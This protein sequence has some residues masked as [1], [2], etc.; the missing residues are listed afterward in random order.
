MLSFLI[1]LTAQN[2]L[3]RTYRGDKGQLI[4]EITIPTI[5]VDQRKPGPV[6]VPTRSAVM[7]AEVPAFDWS[8]G[9]TATSAAMLAG[10]FDRHGYNN[11]YTGPTNGGIVPLDNSA[12]GTGEC[13]L[14]ATHTGYDNLL[15]AGHVNR[16]WTS[17]GNSGDDPFGTGNPTGTYANCTADYIGTS[18][19]WWSNADGYSTVY[20]NDDGSALSNFVAPESYTVR[21]R[22]CTRGL[23][24]FFESRGYTVTANYNQKV[25]NYDGNTLGCTFADYKQ[26]INAG[27]P[28][29]IHLLGRTL[30]HTILG[31]GYDSESNTVY[32]HDTWDYSVH[33]MTWG[34]S[35]SNMVQKGVSVITL[36]P[37]AAPSITWLPTSFSQTLAANL[38]ASQ[39]MSLGNLGSQTLTYTCARASANTTVLDETFAST[40]IPTGWTQIYDTEATAWGFVAGVVYGTPTAAYDGAYNARLFIQSGSESAT[41]LVTPVLNLSGASAAT[42]SFWH[43][44]AKWFGA[45]DQLKVYYKTSVAGAWT[46]L[47]EYT[48]DITSWTQETISLPNLGSTYYI[49]FQGN[50]NYGCGVCLDKIVVTKQGITPTWL[51][52]NGGTTAS[53]SIVSGAASV[54]I[55]VGFNPTGLA[56]GTYNAKINVTSNS[57]ANSAFSIP[58]SMTVTAALPIIITAPT[59]GASWAGGTANNIT[60]SYTGTGS[61]VGLYCSSNNGI[62]WTLIA[63]PATVTGTNNY[64]WTVPYIGSSTYVIKIVNS[65]SPY[66]AAY[67]N[68]F[69]VTSPA[70]TVNQT[71]LDLAT[72]LINTTTTS[73]FNISNSG[74]ATLSGDIS[75]PTGYS[76]AVARNA[77]GITKTKEKLPNR[78]T[79]AYTIAAGSNITYR[80]TFAPTAVQAYNGDIS[81]SSNAG[82]SKTITLTGQG[83][84][85]TLVASATSFTATI[86]A[87][88]TNSQTLTISNSGYMS[89]DYSLTIPAA[90][91]WLQINNT[92]TIANTIASGAA[93]QDIT[94]SFNTTGLAAGNYN[95]TINGTSND[96]NVPTYSI[97]ITLQIPAPPIVITYPA[98]GESIIAGVSSIV[99]W[100]YTGSGSSVYIVVSYDNGVT[101]TSAFMP[102]SCVQGANSTA[103]TYNSHDMSSNV[104]IKII[105]DANPSFEVISN[106]FSVIPAPPRNL[107]IYRYLPLLGDPEAINTTFIWDASLTSS[108]TNY[109]VYIS[110]TTDF[111]PENTTVIMV[112]RTQLAYYYHSDEP[113]LFVRVTSY[114]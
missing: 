103:F 101:W 73:T 39:N 63:N 27:I 65:A 15:T 40:T 17:S 99:S 114:K 60:W 21:K 112:P 100:N 6:V 64:A 66:N 85:P 106:S 12:W 20:W 83:G 11:V 16:F 56:V 89:L 68:V 79:L 44:Q 23:R 29:I 30:G 34:G 76:V 53:G 26:S 96:P 97:E 69:T 7:I 5:P 82:I 31:I 90:I 50:A 32:L 43:T 72:V 46:L 75:M 102:I 104:K 108:I 105:D 107:R 81:I 37:L 49:G 38:T 52:F 48:N 111:L 58:V 51:S 42:L 10:Y 61:T 22:D 28:V 1:A 92:N 93:A 62:A 80:V 4:D 18:Q 94:V 86:E 47:R 87:G 2:S 110:T 91:T 24:L 35:Y 78:N 45:Q 74:N 41:K 54:N 36:A 109:V 113:H 3:V 59:T 33:S 55:S 67:S 71:S 77:T 84:K 57:I 13:S 9:C 98:G 88:S 95:T 25:M 14:S 70:I 19:D 8:Y